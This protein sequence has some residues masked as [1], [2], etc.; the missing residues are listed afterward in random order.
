MKSVRLL[1][2]LEALIAALVI[3]LDIFNPTLVILAIMTLSFAVRKENFFKVGFNK[4][5]MKSLGIILLLVLGLQLFHLSVTKPLL[6]HWTGITQDLSMF[7]SLEGNCAQL[8]L[9][10]ALSWTL[11]AFGEEIAYRGFLQKRLYQISASV[12]TAVIVTSTLFGLAHREQGIIGVTVTALDA[13]FFS[14]LRIRY[15]SLWA[16][17]FAH[18]VSNTIGLVTLYFVGPIYGLW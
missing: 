13:V 10:I 5:S 14:I 1:L 2:I 9:F 7:G 3:I 18:G 6:N 17:I 16:P 12:P 11:S 8:L 15:R 4:I